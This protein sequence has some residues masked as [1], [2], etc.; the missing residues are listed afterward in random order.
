MVARRA[1]FHLV[2][3]FVDYDLLKASQI[4]AMKP[5]LD[6]YDPELFFIE[7]SKTPGFT[8][9]MPESET[10]EP[11]ADLG[12][13]DFPKLVTEHDLIIL[14][15]FSK[16][17]RLEWEMPTVVT[18]TMVAPTGLKPST[19]SERFLPRE[20]FWMVSDYPNLLTAYT[21]S[22]IVVWEEGGMRMFD[23]PN[24]GWMAFNPTLTH[25]LNWTYT[26]DLL[27]GWL[28]SS[29]EPAVWS[30][31]WKDGVYETRPPRL[32]ETV[33]Q[34]WAVV[35]SR[36]ALKQIQALFGGSL[37]QYRQIEHSHIKNGEK[38]MRVDHQ[39]RDLSDA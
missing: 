18:Q 30:V 21:P 9:W 33:A 6:Y 7:P 8:Y 23:S 12:Q 37:T 17:R 13:T 5:V 10:S 3:E 28:N 27:F 20:I 16:V 4:N 29:G 38:K 31:Y 22:P 32:H 2:A 34:G 25:D 39:E 1:F 24:P 19:D 35:G 36:D 26:P 14:G 15:E 11:P